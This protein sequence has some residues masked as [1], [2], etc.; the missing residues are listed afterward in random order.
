ML[1]ALT[2]ASGFI[3]SYAAAAL[4]RAGHEVRALV[5]PTSRREHVAAFVSEWTEGDAA[6]PQ[7]IAGLVAG[8]DVVIHDAADWDALRRAPL[9]N[10]ESNVLGTLRLL[11]AAR[12]AGASQ[13]VFVSSVAVYADIP[14]SANGRI[15]EQTPAWPSGIYGAYK[16]AVEPHLKAYHATYGMNTSSWRP[17]AV[18][19]VDPNLSRSQWFDLIQS[20]KQGG[21]I[22]SAAGGKITHVQDVAEALTLAVGDESVAGQFY[23]LVDQYMYW[24][25]AAEFAKELSGSTATVVDRRGAGP[26]NQFDCAKAIEFFNRHANTTALRRGEAGVREYVAEL[27][28]RS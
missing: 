25:R 24:Q 5:R 18:Y 22:D 28:D 26:K 21:T 13:F 16:A 11:D 27:L 23:N 1:V 9:A 20:A 14:Q 17:A 7:A 19:G 12:Q 3:G 15:T 2:G 4:H 6:D 10:Y 8:V